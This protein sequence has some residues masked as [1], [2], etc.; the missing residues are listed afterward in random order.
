MRLNKL[1]M[2]ISFICLVYHGHILAVNSIQNDNSRKVIAIGDLHGNFKAFSKALKLAKAVDDDLNWKGSDLIVVIVGD[3]MDRGEDEKKLLDTIFRLRLEAKAF[4]SELIALIGNHEAMN[5]YGDFRFVSE[6]GWNDFSSFYDSQNDD[7][8]LKSYPLWKRGRVAA[9]RPGGVYAQKLSQL[10]TVIKIGET[11][12]VH[13][14]VL[15]LYARYGIEK[16]NS[17]MSQWLRGEREIPEFIKD[18]RGPLWNRDFSLLT[19]KKDCQQLSL[20]LDILKARTMVVGHTRFPT[21]IHS[22][23]QNKVY[24]ID[25]GLYSKGPFEILEITEK[26]FKVLK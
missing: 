9:F 26:G 23:C 22:K 16:I 21:G 15:P 3:M 8:I 11:V 12:F 18:R 14:G 25:V 10:K 7:P 13:G 17:Q 6:K 19:S 2:M 5:V 4:N 20:A 1:G 24:R